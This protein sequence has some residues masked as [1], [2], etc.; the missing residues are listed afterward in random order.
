[1]KTAPP[2]LP[3]DPGA[4]AQDGDGT[5]EDESADSGKDKMRLDPTEEFA[6]H[7]FPPFVHTQLNS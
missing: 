6:T 1:M 7:F 5:D 4:L 3:T 2:Y